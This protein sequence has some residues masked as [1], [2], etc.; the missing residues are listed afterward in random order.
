MVLRKPLWITLA[1]ASLSGL[2][3]AL[4]V[5]FASPMPAYLLRAQIWATTG[6]IADIFAPLGYCLLIGV[7]LKI[8]G[9]AGII[10][11]Q[12]ALHVVT[13]YVGI[14][15]LRELGLPERWSAFG[16]LTIAL[17]PV[18]LLSVTKV[19][20]VQLST[21]LF[22]L[23][24][25]LCLRLRRVP[26]ASFLWTATVAGLVFAAGAFCRPNY[27]FLLP[28]FGLIL[29]HR[30][31]SVQLSMLS[32]ATLSF[33]VIALATW[34]LLAIAAHG[35]VFFPNN[36]SYNLY[37]GHNPQAAHSLVV[38]L[39]GEP[40]LID[41]VHKGYSADPNVDFSSPSIRVFYSQQAI[42]FI[43][44]HPGAEIALV[45]LK[46]FTFFRP[47]TKVHPLAS[48]AGL[49]QGLLSLPIVLF[50]GLLFW[51]GRLALTF[52]DRLLFLFEA[53]YIVPF[54]ITN[55]D[56]RFRVPLDALLLLHCVSLLFRRIQ[57]RQ[58]LDQ[59]NAES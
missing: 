53:A 55:S 56:P 5:P 22:L 17:N 24:V 13:T 58:S 52:S 20:D 7:V 42:L 28:V 37:A 23:F 9:S 8:A 29:I 10:L 40:S 19:W 54:L 47:D 49:A 41:E 38:N 18:L 2:C 12:L 39:N 6:G 46:L 50:L 31:K 14:L 51:P 30:R 57:L 1:L 25:L 34:A 33:A 27:L 43:R 44:T 21:L 32:A 11:L 45:P 35:S 4:F 59:Q 26:A 48:P 16:A 3:V 15:L 36:G